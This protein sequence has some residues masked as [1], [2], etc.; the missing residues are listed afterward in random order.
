MNHSLIEEAACRAGITLLEE[1]I[2]QVDRYVE[3]LKEENQKFN[4]TSIIEDEAIAIRHLEDSW[5]AASLFKK[6]SSLLDVGTGAGFP[7]LALK[8]IRP[9]LE[10][11]LL[12]ATG[13]KVVFLQDTIRLLDLHGVSA[14]QGRG[15]ELGRN[16]LY[17]ERFDQVIARAVSALPELS[18]L[19][20]PLVKKGGSFIAM[21][22]QDD[23]V[24]SAVRAISLLGAVH[25]KTIRYELLG[26][27]APRSLVMIKKRT[28]SPRRFPRRMAT[29]RQSPL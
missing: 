8:I 7:G 15:E 11:T 1:Q 12:D 6:G 2:F 29:I 17:R 27:D 22:G 20:L 18:E 9:D 16:P 25:E 3:H 14:L 13:K 10:V 4:L 24:K 21:K 19:C 23:E 26:M 5:H 28:A